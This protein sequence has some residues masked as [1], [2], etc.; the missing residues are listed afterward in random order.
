MSKQAYME[1]NGSV[2]AHVIHLF[3]NPKLEVF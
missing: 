1:E 2:F 3:K